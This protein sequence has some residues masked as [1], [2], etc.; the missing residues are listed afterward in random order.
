M[1]FTNVQKTNIKAFIKTIFWHQFCLWK[2]P[3]SRFFLFSPLCMAIFFKTFPSSDFWGVKKA[4]CKKVHVFGENWQRNHF[5]KLTTFWL[6]LHPMLQ[7]CH[8]AMCLP[9]SWSQTNQMKVQCKEIKKR[10]R[11]V[12]RV[13]ASDGLFF[14]RLFVFHQ[15]AASWAQPGC[16]LMR[17]A[18]GQFLSPLT[19][20]IHILDEK[21]GRVRVISVSVHLWNWSSVC[22]VKAGDNPTTSVNA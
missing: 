7:L 16:H 11:H 3:P 19:W 20:K 1:F 5:P 17:N 22:N 9:L 15:T 14:N 12:G 21:L 2:T 8:S 18:G 4:S 13:E 10:G 6:L